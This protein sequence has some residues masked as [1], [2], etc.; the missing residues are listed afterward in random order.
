MAR[1]TFTSAQLCIAWRAQATADPKGTRGDVV[2]ALIAEMEME[3]NADNRK[4]V[5]NNVTQRVAQLSKH[6]TSPI[7]FQPLAEGKKGARRTDSDL[8]ALQ[9]LLNGPPVDEG[10]DEDDAADAVDA[11]KDAVENPAE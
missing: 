6:K 5:Y 2:A 1:A 9:A 8:A 3:D 7:R 10:D 4:R 11:A